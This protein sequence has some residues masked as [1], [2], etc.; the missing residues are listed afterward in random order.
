M[1]DEGELKHAMRSGG[2]EGEVE[3]LT[4]R[5]LMTILSPGDW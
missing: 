4:T 5:S 1:D 3:L 2:G